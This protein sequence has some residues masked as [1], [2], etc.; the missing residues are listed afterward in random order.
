MKILFLTMY[1][2]RDISERGIYTDLMREF[3][4]MDHQ[5]YIATPS[6]RRYKESANVIKGDGYS[7]LPVRTLN[8]Q[9][10]NVVEKGIGILILEYQ[11]QH[12][13]KRE[14]GD[15]NFDLVLYSTPPITLNKVIEWQKRRGTKSY[16]MLKDIFP[17]NAVDLGMMK[18]GGLVWK[19]LAR[20]EK[21][22]YKLS[23]YIG[24]MSPANC[25]YLLANNPDI[26]KDKVEE[27]PNSISPKG[28]DSIISGA[29]ANIINFGNNY[30][31]C[32]YGGNIGK[33]QGVD[34]IL[35]VLDAVIGLPVNICI[36][37]SGT[38]SLKLH[39]W[40]DS[41]G[42]VNNVRFFDAVNK[43]SY[44]Q[45]VA[46]ADI[47]MI[48]LDNR[49]TIP[50]FPSRLLSYLEFKKPVILATDKNTDIGHIAEQNKFGL[51][52]ESGDLESFLKNIKI[53]SKNVELRNKMGENG[54]RFLLNNYTASR[55]AGII[56]S[57]FKQ[58]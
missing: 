50:N 45:I 46:N 48:F 6:E 26:S 49:F 22:L 56:L 30:P 36:V 27:C 8:L 28:T 44:D 17:Q 34:F 39:K 43:E 16:L 24:C 20:K 53:L 52:C 58:H 2:I 9:K 31:V 40:L 57:H 35:Q 41:H 19:M 14:W 10:T 3:I 37:G 42:D 12:A 38:E 7:I 23:D 55:T 47:G 32:L 4:R 54:Y 51:W 18:K 25:L 13:I 21:R 1:R 11:Y 33:P 15:I 5:V 29:T